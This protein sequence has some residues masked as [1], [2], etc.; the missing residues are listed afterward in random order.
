MEVACPPHLI[1]TFNKFMNP[2]SQ[3]V[4]RSY[5]VFAHFS[6]LKFDMC[7]KD[8]GNLNSRESFMN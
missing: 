4:A 3:L 1:P 6:A 8:A 2:T 5:F 7:E